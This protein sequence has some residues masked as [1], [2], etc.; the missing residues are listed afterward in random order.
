MSN[1]DTTKVAPTLKP[2]DWEDPD[3]KISAYFVIWGFALLFVSIV[4]LQFVAYTFM[5]MRRD[6]AATPEVREGAAARVT[7]LD[8]AQF[9]ADQKKRLRKGEVTIEKAMQQVVKDNS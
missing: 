7:G 3:A 1:A 8:P 4:G 2:E 6:E 9:K 5:E